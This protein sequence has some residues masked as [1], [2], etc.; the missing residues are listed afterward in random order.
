M[1]FKSGYCW[2]AAYD[3]H[4]NLYTA[5]FFSAMSGSCTL[6][7]IDKEIYDLLY[8]GMDNTAQSIFRAGRKLYMH[9]NDQCGSPYTIVFDKNYKDICPW[10]LDSVL[11]PNPEETWPDEM[12]NAV[13]TVLGIRKNNTE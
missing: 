13:A 5:G 6:Y 10:A 12:T 7:E 11:E 2:E 8:D 9:V 4:R 3:E 1:Q